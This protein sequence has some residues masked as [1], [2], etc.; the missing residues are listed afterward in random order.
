MRAFPV[1]LSLLVACG[2][3]PTHPAKA[4]REVAL[5]DLGLSAENMDRATDPCSDFYR[6]ACGAWLDHTEIPPERVSVGYLQSLGDQALENLRAVLEEA[7][8]AP[9]DKVGDYYASCM[10]EGAIERNGRRALAPLLTAIEGIHDAATAGAAVVELHRAGVFSVF[11]FGSTQDL[12]DATRTI[13][14][15]DSGGLLLPDRD[16]YFPTSDVGKQLLD[17]YRAHA[18][19]M[20]ALFGAADAAAG[21]A[22]ETEL[23]RATMTRVERRRSEGQYH[24]VTR[25][26][27]TSMAPHFPWDLYFKRLSHPDLSAFT[28]ASPAYLRRVD[29]LLATTPPAAWR[30]YLTLHLLDTLADALPHAFDDEHFA[31]DRL[32]T[33][34]KQQQQR[35]RRCV[36][37]TD[38]RLAELVA[39]PYLKKVFSDDARSS[40]LAMVRALGDALSAD[41]DEVSWMDA[42]TRARARTKLSNLVFL[43]GFPEVF[44][45]YDWPVDRSDYTANVLASQTYEVSRDLDHTRHPTDRKEWHTSPATVNMYNDQ[46]RNVLTFPAAILQPPYFDPHHPPQINLAG[47]GMLAGHEFTHTLDDEGAKFDELGN[48]TAWWSHDIV[49]RFQERTQCV[50]HQYSTYEALPGEHVNGDLTLGENIAD[51]GGLKIAYRA[52]HALRASAPET[53]VAGGLDEDQQFFLGFAQ[54][55][56]AKRTVAQQRNELATNPHAPTEFR[57]NGTLADRPEFG[58]AFHCPV[59]IPM[60]PAHPCEVW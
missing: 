14:A 22:L 56:C 13:A 1:A 15:I 33:G 53:L 40:A 39:R 38:A 18:A 3:G 17:E 34:R 10:D 43:V 16:F 47:V 6:Y 37:D 60:R 58:Q 41:L 46:Q 57:V 51:I 35:W 4:T 52:Y 31:L 12:K 32:L 36:R 55:W 54:A 25:A 20:L 24:L 11:T 2:G 7:A 50:A 9:G 27:L 29:E 19:R 59:G 42:P 21:L 44:R 5:T 8:R 26:E 45:P 28:V 49:E 30:A 23:A 48:V